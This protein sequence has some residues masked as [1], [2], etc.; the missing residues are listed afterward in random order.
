MVSVSG[1]AVNDP[2]VNED[3]YGRA[4]PHS[5]DLALQGRARDLRELARR[6][7]GD[8]A[9][10]RRGDGGRQRHAELARGVGEVVGRRGAHHGV[11]HL[12]HN[13]RAEDLAHERHGAQHVAG[14]AHR[15]AAVARDDR[16]LAHR[17][18]EAADGAREWIAS[19]MANIT[20]GDNAAG[21][22]VFGTKGVREAL[23]AMARAVGTDDAR[24]WIASAMCNIT[25]DNADGARVFST[26][27]VREVLVA[28]ARAADTDDTREWI[29][30]AVCNVTHGNTAGAIIFNT[31]EM[32]RMLETLRTQTQP[33]IAVCIDTALRDLDEAE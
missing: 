4:H 26:E 17:V 18:A 9:R 15:L 7:R 6:L 29:V 27:G 22:R 30:K 33:A 10:G 32:R 19:A 23:V 12:A 5:R 3:V 2:C 11:A 25:Y 1:C 20:G 21:R 16:R 28:M 31:A 14:D 24:R 13:A 8:L